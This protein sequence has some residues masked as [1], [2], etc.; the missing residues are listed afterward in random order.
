MNIA[1]LWLCAL[2]FGGGTVIGVQQVLSSFLLDKYSTVKDTHIH[3]KHNE[4]KYLNSFKYLFLG[5]QT[6][7]I[8]YVF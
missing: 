6:K 4:A 3:T 5:K 1:E 2:S 8:R 7:A